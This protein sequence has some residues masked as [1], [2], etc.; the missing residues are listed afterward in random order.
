M[1][2]LTSWLIT[3]QISA[4]HAGDTAA[5]G[6]LILRTHVYQN[7]IKCKHKH[8]ILTKMNKNTNLN[9]QLHEKPRNHLAERV[10][11]QEAIFV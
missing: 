2:T 6:T 9:K 5:S 4:S 7:I 10:I 11:Y 8:C 1:L 3:L